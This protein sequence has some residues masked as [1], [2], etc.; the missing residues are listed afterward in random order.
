MLLPYHGPVG[1]H[2]APLVR[3]KWVMASLAQMG[4]LNGAHADSG[5]VCGLFWTCGLRAPGFWDTATLWG[6]EGPK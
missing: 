4:P 2:W 1:A 6:P 5:P 3:A